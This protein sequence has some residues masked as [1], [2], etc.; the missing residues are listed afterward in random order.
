VMY[1]SM[2]IQDSKYESDDDKG[3]LV[4]RVNNYRSL[5][6]AIGEISGPITWGALDSPRVYFILLGIFSVPM[7]LSCLVPEKMHRDTV[8]DITHPI[9][10]GVELSVDGQDL[11]VKKLI[12]IGNK[13][14]YRDMYRIANRDEEDGDDRG[15]EED[16]EDDSN[17][18]KIVIESETCMSNLKLIR[19]SLAHPIIRYLLMYNLICTLFPS[20]SIPM[21]FFIND[22]VKITPRDVS[23]IACV[24][25][26]TRIFGGL[27]YQKFFRT[28]SI[29]YIYGVAT[30]VQAITEYVPYLLTK[31]IE[32][33]EGQTC[34][35]GIGWDRNVTYA[36]G[37]CYL[38]EY[39]E[40][41]PVFLLVGDEAISEIVDKLKD[42]PLM[43]LVQALCK[44]SVEASTYSFVQSVQNTVGLL[45][46]ISDAETIV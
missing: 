46:R 12:K 14:Q 24:T 32:L 37:T 40:I 38:Y 15:E 42:M 16:E 10:G 34:G 7:I 20:A 25:E 5:G 23:I 22:E 36:N 28:R 8:K 6:W 45:H 9:S 39:L 33:K 2:V 3:K 4:T 43:I 21:F 44:E 19:Q 31:T 27:L 11:K 1:D 30:V 29:W 35:D 13:K 26:F 18:E 17:G 41:N